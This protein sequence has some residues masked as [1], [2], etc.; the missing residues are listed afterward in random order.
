[1]AASVELGS[2][3]RVCTQRSQALTDAAKYFKDACEIFQREATRLL[4]P[5]HVQET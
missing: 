2:F 4:A 3:V 5:R 1:M